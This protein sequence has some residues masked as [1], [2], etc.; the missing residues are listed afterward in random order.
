[1]STE[2]H[3]LPRVGIDLV[4]VSRIEESLSHFGQRFLRRLF[5][6]DEIAYA[7]ASPATCAQRLAARFAAKEAALKALNVTRHGVAWRDIEVRRD[8]DGAC[9]L[10]LHATARSAARQRGLAVVSLS[11]THEGDY[12]AAVV[13]AQPQN[14]SAFNSL[15]GNQ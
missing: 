1:M 7:L 10:V 11:L 14:P 5:H 2:S 6:Q 3:V 12:A 8:A 13:L 4:R 9:A 15:H